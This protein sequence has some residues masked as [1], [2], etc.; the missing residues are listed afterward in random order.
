MPDSAAHPQTT[1]ALSTKLEEDFVAPLTA[2]RG[3]LEILRDYPDLEDAKRLRFVSTALR[4][5]S[6]LERAVDELADS[7]YTAGQGSKDAQLA[8]PQTS[9]AETSGSRIHIHDDLDIFE[10]DFSDFTFS[11]A[12]V[13]NQLFDEID[14]AVERSGKKWYFLVNN[15]GTSIWPEAW[16]AYAHRSKK[17]S[18]NEAHATVRYAEPEEGASDK[19]TQAAGTRQGD[20][21]ES[22]EEALQAIAE[23]KSRS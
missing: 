13:V 4:S 11:S 20:Q 18:V 7:V 8:S 21:Y 3:A 15:R 22:R 1:L 12:V 9:R 23:M 5:C 17:V 10:I 6:R 19:S 14:E 2:I 16:V